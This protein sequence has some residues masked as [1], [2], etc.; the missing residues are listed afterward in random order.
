[1]RL[2]EHERSAAQADLDRLTGELVRL[3][4]L[5]EQ[6]KLA[7]SDGEN[8]AAADA[9]IAIGAGTQSGNVAV[10]P[11]FQLVVGKRDGSSPRDETQRETL[12]A[13]LQVIRGGLS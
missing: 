13:Q 3:Y 12:R 2:N 10:P 9:P 11:A 5:R 1:M 8:G 7:L 6:L 4:Q